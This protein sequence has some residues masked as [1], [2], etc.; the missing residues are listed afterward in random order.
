VSGLIPGL[1]VIVI[2]AVLVLWL[3]V[4]E[5]FLRWRR[6]AVSQ[7][8]GLDRAW[9]DVRHVLAPEAAA[10]HEALDPCNREASIAACEAILAATPER[11]LR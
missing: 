5:R 2:G 10:G 8:D 4:Y 1:V 3:P 7:H 6:R 11:S 9:R